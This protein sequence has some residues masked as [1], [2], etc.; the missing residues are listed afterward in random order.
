MGFGNWSTS[1]TGASCRI[2]GH[3]ALNVAPQHPSV[4]PL[5]VTAELAFASSSMMPASNDWHATG[6]GMFLAV[7]DQIQIGSEQ[8]RSPRF[9][10]AVDVDVQTPIPNFACLRMFAHDD[11]SGEVTVVDMNTGDPKDGGQYVG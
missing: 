2:L 5:S 9:H 7:F 6:S 1:C 3:F 10:Y 4:T 8:I 11:S